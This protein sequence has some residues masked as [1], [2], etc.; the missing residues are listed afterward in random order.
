LSTVA[1]TFASINST[2]PRCRPMPLRSPS[3]IFITFLLVLSILAGV[4]LAKGRASTASSAAA[5][6]TLDLRHPYPNQRVYAVSDSAG[7]VFLALK[8]AAEQF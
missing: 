6:Y 3:L 4:S 2:L 1:D 5:A 7:D 8:Y